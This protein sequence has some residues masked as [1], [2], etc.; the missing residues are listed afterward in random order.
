MCELVAAGGQLQHSVR[1]R[2]AAAAGSETKSVPGH[3]RK[4]QVQLPAPKTK[5][6][7]EVNTLHPKKKAAD[8]VRTAHQRERINSQSEHRREF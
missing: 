3:I 4:P 8:G 2:Y 5:G 7:N 6:V 1:G